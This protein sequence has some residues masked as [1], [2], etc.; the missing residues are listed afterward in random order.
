M[1]GNSSEAFVKQTASLMKKCE[2]EE[3]EKIITQIHQISIPAESTAAM[4][5]TLNL[6]WNQLC[7][8]SRWLATFNIKIASEKTTRNRWID[9]GLMA[10]LA[11]LTHKPNTGKKRIIAIPRPWVYIYNIVGHILKRI[12]D[13]DEHNQLVHHNFIPLNEIHIKIGGDHGGNT[14][15]MGYQIG[16]IK[17]PNRKENTTIFSIFEAKDSISNLRTCLE[18]FKAQIKLLQRRNWKKFSLRVFIYGDYEY[19]CTMYGISGANGNCLRCTFFLVYAQH[20][21]HIF[22]NVIYNLGINHIFL[23]GRVLSG[24]IFNIHFLQVDTVAFG[25]QSRITNRLCIPKFIRGTSESRTLE[26][27][28]I[29]LEQFKVNGSKLKDAKKF[30]NV[31]NDNFFKTP[32]QVRKYFTQ[33]RSK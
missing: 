14:F 20:C 32:L 13:L 16:N 24:L 22:D 21:I 18:R 30:N 23:N 4:K 6:P 15:K 25:A 8:I 26:S 9:E 1:S 17:N 27:L 19:L 7:N 28:Q 33:S 12:N 29:N 2:K 31:I 10:E 3:R 11:P 5:A